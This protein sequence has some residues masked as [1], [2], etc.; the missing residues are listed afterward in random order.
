MG[1]V[2]YTKTLMFMIHTRDHGFPHV[3][4]YKGTPD[5]HEAF[6]KIRLDVIDIIES[7]GFGTKALTSIVGI[8][9]ENRE[10][11]LEE[12]NETRAK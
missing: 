9:A 12:W 3:T 6:A 11:W 5:N 4:V 8:T 10:A 2:L 1:T 7:Q